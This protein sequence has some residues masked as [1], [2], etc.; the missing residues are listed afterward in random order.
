MLNPLQPF[1][2]LLLYIALIFLR[3]HEYVAAL[4]DLPILPAV[5]ALAFGL[6]MVRGSKR[7]DAPQHTL[8]PLFIVGMALSLVANGWVG[9]SIEILSQFLPVLVLFYLTAMTVDTLTRQRQMF[10]VIAVVTTVIALHGVEQAATGTGWSGARAVQDGRITYLGFLNDPNDLAIAFLIALPMTLYLARS[11]PRFLLRLCGYSAALLLLYGIYLTNSRGGF[12]ALAVI[13]GLHLSRRLG[14]TRSLLLAPLVLVP[15]LALAPSRLGTVSA[16]EESAAERVESWYEGMQMFIANPVFG[17]GKGNF[18]E[19]HH[20]T[21]HNSFILVYSETGLVGYFFW[22]SLVALSLLMLI[23]IQKSALPASPPTESESDASEWQEHQRIA[24]VLLY[25]LV[26]FLVSS[27]FLSRSYVVLLYFLIALIV[28]AYQT[29]R[30]RWPDFSPVR[31]GPVLGRM[32]A[33]ELGS[34]VFFF[35]LTRVLLRLS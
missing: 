32:V 11:T 29:V 17:V 16:T 35:L 28:A 34:I 1:F 5:L 4:A 15:L 26:G 22:L 18:T 3:P 20:L 6:W 8:F 14:I 31:L 27:L 23:R 13:L 12:L 2:Y 10:L 9:G 24:R 30:T 19:Y 21:A 25:S 7:F 33:L